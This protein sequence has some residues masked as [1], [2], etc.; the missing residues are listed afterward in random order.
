VEDLETWR[1][2]AAL[3]CDLAQ[4]YFVSP[5]IPAN[6]LAAWRLPEGVRQAAAH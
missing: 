3:K 4:G 2:L 1:R 5:P 6:E